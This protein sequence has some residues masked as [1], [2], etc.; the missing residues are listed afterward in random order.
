[1][2]EKKEKQKHEHPEDKPAFVEKAGECCGGHCNAQVET[3]EITDLQE[4]IL[5]E[6]FFLMYHLHIQ[7]SEIDAMPPFTRKWLIQRFIH[8]KKVEKEIMDQMR[9]GVVSQ[10]FLKEIERTKN[11]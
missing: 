4:E 3:G 1:L 10:D 7:P 9:R 2:S 5:E 8:Q 11:G 6:Q